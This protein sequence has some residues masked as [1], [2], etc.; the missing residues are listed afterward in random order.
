MRKNSIIVLVFLFVLV[1]S[2]KKN[3]TDSVDQNQVDASR[4]KIDS[5][6]DQKEREKAVKKIPADGKYPVMTFTET[7]FDFGDIKQGDRVEH[8]FEFTNTGE[9]DLIITSARATCGC[10]VPEY[11]EEPIKP[12]KSGKIKVTFNSTGKKGQTSK[13]ITVVCNTAIENEKLTIKTNIQVPN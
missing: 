11:T 4:S 5:I 6:I 2:C 7:E 3:T 9:A 12:G 13:T 8:T 1:V 10:T